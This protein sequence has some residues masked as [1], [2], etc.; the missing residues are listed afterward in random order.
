MQK[1]LVLK[2]SFIL[3]SALMIVEMILVITAYVNQSENLYV[4]AIVTMWG[5][6]IIYCLLDIYNRVFFFIYLLAF[7]NFLIGRSL[8]IILGIF[9]EPYRFTL[10]ESI[11]GQQIV[12]FSLIVLV[13]SYILLGKS[14]SRNMQIMNADSVSIQKVRLA[15]K[16]LF[17]ST[18]VFLVISVLG[19]IFYV[20]QNGYASIYVDVEAKVPTIIKKIGDIAPFAFYL[21]LGTLPT[22]KEVRLPLMLYTIY[23]ILT[24]GTG[25]RF[26]F[27]IGILSILTYFIL[28]NS[29]AKSESEKWIRKRSLK[30]YVI[31]GFIIIAML[32]AYNNLRFNESVETTSPIQLITKFSFDQGISINI[33]KR[34]FKYSNYIPTDRFYSLDSTISFFNKNIGSKLFGTIYYSGASVEKA[35]NGNSLSDV[36]SYI[37][38]KSQYLLGIGGG[39]SYIAEVYLDFGWL[40]LFIINIIYSFLFVKL[41][42]FSLKSPYKFLIAFVIFMAFLRTPRGRTDGV[43]LKIFD[44]MLWISLIIIYFI[45]KYMI[46]VKRVRK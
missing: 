18:F 35:I 38:Y 11:S 17:L 26:E 20:I 25:A 1:N 41:E 15:S 44:P 12:L 5:I 19:T 24:L 22:K 16:V 8:L 9:K 13:S 43:I 42:D 3:L 30:Y 33:P 45:T 39:S 46:K 21:F 2:N 36:L 14:I 6:G 40:G 28:R 4:Y 37:L 31:L 23:L 32:S 29:L 27:V 34:I 10:Q 7:F